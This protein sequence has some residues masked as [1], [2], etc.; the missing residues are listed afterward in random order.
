VKR[1]L[2]FG[3]CYSD[4]PEKAR[5]L[6]MWSALAL[7]NKRE[8]LDVMVVDSQSPSLPHIPMP[9]R[10][11]SFR[12]NIGHLSRG[13][14][15]G[16]GRAFSYGL[17]RAIAEGYDYA[18]HVECDS[19]L[20]PLIEPAIGWM[21]HQNVQVASTRVSSAPHHWVETG[22]MLFRTS[23]IRANNFLQQYDWERRNRRPEPEVVIRG[24][25]GRDL[26]YLN[27]R[28]M[29]DDFK[30]LTVANLGSYKLDWLT[31]ATIDVMEQFY[32]DRSEK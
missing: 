28:T 8:G 5:V 15:D 18:I 25:V 20:L 24:L 17:F 31:H 2:L 7:R 26:R 21:E 23:W 16:W 6:E 9:I 1:A 29:R 12:D 14:R 13:G 32:N 10:Y 4:G 27:W 30:A 22:L 3:T 11:Y 19:L